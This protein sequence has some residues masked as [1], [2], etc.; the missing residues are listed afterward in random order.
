MDAASGAA[1]P[2]LQLR[3]WGCAFGRKIVLDGVELSLA[4]A[5]GVDV[6]MGPVKTGKSTLMRTL[7]GHYARNSLL[8]QWGAACLL[9]ESLQDGNRPLLLQQHARLLD[10]PLHAV[11]V[12]RLREL[13][14][15]S[16]PQWRDRAAQ[17]LQDTGLTDRVRNLDQ[18]VLQLPPVL[19]R[20]VNIA[21]LVAV[22]P[23]L[24]MVDEPT[25]GLAESDAH[26][27]I[28]WLRQIGTRQ[29]LLVSLHH[30]QQARRLG[31]RVILIGGGR[32]LAH[33]DISAFFLHPANAWVE[34]FVHSGSLDL[35]SPG[36]RPEDLEAPEFQPFAL[37]PQA[38]AS[39]Q[40]FAP[41]PEEPPPPV[42]HAPAAMPAD[43]AVA[44]GTVAP[45]SPA[46]AKPATP[47]RRPP[48]LPLPS[49]EGVELVSAVGKVFLSEYRGPKGFQWIIPGMLAGCPEPGISATADYDLDLLSSVG[50]TTLITLTERDVDQHALQRHGLKNL[51][52]P[53]FDRE[54]PSVPQVHM[55]L[56]RMQRLLAA[57]EVLA[58]HCKAGLG[59]T[60]TVLAAWMIREGGL[61]A[62]VAI[63]RLRRV[64]PRYIQSDAQE[65]FLHKYES[66]LIERLP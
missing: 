19:Q 57:G 36:A 2:V 51:H 9:G 37:S 62:A 40:Q 39:L 25:Y 12:H 60:G 22:R 59:R 35:P 61:T 63:E 21:S 33:Q 30:Q 23:A 42:P 20:S 41:A 18:P 47:G 7:A 58:V 16:A 45:T 32:V 54:A 65:Q 6:L 31:D 43:T 28:D 24:L 46:E 55:L 38:V 5:H 44:A 3:D 56:T 26:A 4:G 48:P 8:H 17:V 52:L 53:V 14:T 64:E 11:L 1:A 15:L 34:K 66:D 49:R 10:Q 50:I 13:G 29:R 27:L